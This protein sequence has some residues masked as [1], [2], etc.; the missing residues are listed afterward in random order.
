[1]RIPYACFLLAA[2]T[3]LAN[4]KQVKITVLATT[5]LHGHIMPYDYF[6]GKEAAGG[7]AKIGTLIQNQRKANANTLLIDCGDTIQG[8]ALESY[9][10]QH[11]K[12][13]EMPPG[14]STDPMMLAMN[15]LHY[16]AMAVGNHE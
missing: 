2:P 11:V 9:Y 10:Q 12:T 8:S 16:D 1:M 5:D 6:T 13:G 4:A 14:L 3:L 15:Y 7:L